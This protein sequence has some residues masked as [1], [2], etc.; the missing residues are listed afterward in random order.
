MLVK[1]IVNTLIVRCIAMLSSREALLAC[2]GAFR[3]ALSN[4]FQFLV[5]FCY[6][7]WLLRTH[8]AT[9]FLNAA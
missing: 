8:R 1:L 5:L 4:V 7:S 9:R 3:R 6:S 2:Y